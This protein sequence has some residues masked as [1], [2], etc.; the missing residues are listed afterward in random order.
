MNIL[1]IIA[2]FISLTSAQRW[3]QFGSTEYFF[4]QEQIEFARAVKTCENLFATLVVIDNKIIQEFLEDVISDGTSMYLSNIY[5]V[6][7]V[8]IIRTIIINSLSI[9]LDLF[10]KAK[11]LSSCAIS[12][13]LLTIT[14]ILDL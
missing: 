10:V 2:C 7:K 8:L 11:E 3:Q 5:F 9:L 14:A 12:I 4:G 1:L 6:K 13:C